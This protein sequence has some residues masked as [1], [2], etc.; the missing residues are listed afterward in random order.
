MQTVIGGFIK[1]YQACNASV[2]DLSLCGCRGFDLEIV[3]THDTHEVGLHDM[4]QLDGDIGVRCVDFP[5]H[6]L[7][8]GVI[9]RSL[10]HVLGGFL[11]LFARC[12]RQTCSCYGGTIDN[13]LELVLFIECL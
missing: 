8:F 3:H 11:A 2:L 7:K 1:R 9:Q 12:G 6:V 10:Q 5:S 13:L 4:V